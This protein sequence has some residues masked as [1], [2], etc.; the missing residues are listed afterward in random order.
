MLSRIAFGD[1]NS[2]IGVQLQLKE[3]HKAVSLVLIRLVGP[4]KANRALAE[5]RKEWGLKPL[6]IKNGGGSDQRRF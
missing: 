1:L 4:T 6:R 5:V 3:A 2:R